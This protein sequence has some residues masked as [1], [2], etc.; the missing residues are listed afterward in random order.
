VN[1]RSYLPGAY[2]ASLLSRWTVTTNFL[3]LIFLV[4]SQSDSKVNFMCI[5]QIQ[6]HCWGWVIIIAT[7]LDK[8]CKLITLK[9]VSRC[10]CPPVSHFGPVITLQFSS[11]GVLYL[12]TSR[13]PNHF[14]IINHLPFAHMI[15]W[16]QISLSFNIQQICGFLLQSIPPVG[17]YWCL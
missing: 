12:L 6:G 17:F 15:R 8:Q 4:N 16:S 5:K 2:Y 1:L 9:V 7:R 11:G 14:L 3:L 13:K 10:K